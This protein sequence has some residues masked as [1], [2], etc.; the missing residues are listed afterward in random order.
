[1][2]L[3]APAILCLTASVAASVAALASDPMRSC[4]A[5]G[6]TVA[7]VAALALLHFDAP[8][9]AAAILVAH[10]GLGVVNARLAQ[11]VCDSDQASVSDQAS[12]PPVGGVRQIWML[13]VIVT[14]SGVLVVSLAPAA[15]PMTGAEGATAHPGTNAFPVAALSL[16]ALS[17][18]LGLNAVWRTYAGE[19]Q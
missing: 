16:A 10:G 15:A 4:M 2:E 17:A 12:A 5:L 19:G 11:Q 6:V 18:I 14:F 9:A 3:I 7:S 1:M 13:A 8:L